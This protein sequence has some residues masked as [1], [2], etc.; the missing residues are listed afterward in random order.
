VQVTVDLSDVVGKSNRAMTAQFQATEQN[1]DG[2]DP[3]DSS[4][5]TVSKLS[6]CKRMYQYPKSLS[7]NR[8]LLF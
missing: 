2:F 3:A 8:R 5:S 7:M 1:V 6:S 4:N